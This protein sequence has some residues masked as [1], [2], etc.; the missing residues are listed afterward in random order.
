MKAIAR[1]VACLAQEAMQVHV[2]K[3]RQDTR[4]QKACSPNPARE[5]HGRTNRS[6]RE[7]RRKIYEG[8]YRQVS[9]RDKGSRDSP[10]KGIAGRKEQAE[11]RTA[12]GDRMKLSYINSRTGAPPPPGGVPIHY[13]IRRGRENASI[14]KN[15]TGMRIFRGTHKKHE[16]IPVV[17]KARSQNATS[18]IQ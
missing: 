3:K 15:S 9:S 7:P 10:V 4:Q 14:Y 1:E 5:F 8:R 18:E 6:R 12:K 17:P 11:R 2:Q 13:I 16:G